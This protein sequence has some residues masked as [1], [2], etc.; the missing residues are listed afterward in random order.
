MEDKNKMNILKILTIELK[1]SIKSI[2]KVSLVLSLFMLLVLL[3]YDPDLFA[4]IEDM[5]VNYPE[6]ILALIGGTI[7]LGTLSGFITVEFL[8]MIWIWVGIYIILK[9]AQDIPTAIDNKSIDLILSKPIKR[10]EYALGK[11][12]CFIISLLI[13]FLALILMIV[14][15]KLIL[16]N[17]QDENIIWKEY[18]VAFFW[19]FLFCTALECTAFL[20][21][22]FMP[23]K[24]ASGI[25]FIV[26]I[27]FFILGLYYTFFDESIQDLKYLSIFHYYDPSRIMVN[28]E[29][30]KFMIDDKFTG[31]LR[32]FIIL[33]GYSIVLSISSLIIFNNRDI[34]V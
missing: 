33:T 12:L 2:L 10:W 18:F 13:I 28:H 15:M 31:V 14:I 19:S 34:P 27:I 5:L 25:S 21:S 20:F 16:P 7:S 8:S 6:E 30:I 4:G 11:H 32:D 26:L 1:K 23:R 22:T 29:P 9:A 17:L 24:Q 3:I